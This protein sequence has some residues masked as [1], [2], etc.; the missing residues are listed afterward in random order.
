MSNKS[1]NF[2]LPSDLDIFKAKIFEHLRA[3][4]PLNGKEGVY[5]S[6]M[7]G[8]EISTAT[9][10]AVTDKLLP[11]ITQW[12]NRPLESIYPIIFLDAMF[13]KARKN[14]EKDTL[15]SLNHGLS[16]GI[17]Y[18]T[19]PIERFHRQ[20]RKFTKKKAHLLQKMLYLS[21]FIV[22]VKRFKHDG[23]NLYITGP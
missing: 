15:Q 13:F 14:W 7:Y 17:I 5:L 6:D 11:M 23:I 21:L 16:I 8:V 18:T 19:N 1:S 20:V 2:D 9:I 12:R 22:P 3:G 10:S 4:K